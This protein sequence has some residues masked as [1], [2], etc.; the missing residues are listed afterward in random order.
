MSG[1]TVDFL[2]NNRQSQKECFMKNKLKVLGIIVLAAI[3][4]FS[5]FSCGGGS[6]G[7]LSITD[8]EKYNGKFAFAVSEDDIPIVA[9]KSIDL[10]KQT[11]TGGQIINGSVSL[12]VYQVSDDDEISDYKGSEKKDFFVGISNEATFDNPIDF[13]IVSVTFTK[14]KAR[15]KFISED[16]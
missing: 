15:G 5:M 4:G 3:I 13:G 11:I 8:L 1:K 16:D 7:R 6:S 9:A 12:N 2:K 14:G 10:A